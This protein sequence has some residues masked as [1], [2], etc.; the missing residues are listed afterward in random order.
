MIATQNAAGI[1]MNI[2]KNAQQP[3]NN[4]PQNAGRW[5]RCNTPVHLHN[6][7]TEMDNLMKNIGILSLSFILIAS[8]KQ[9]GSTNVAATIA[10][11][12][13]PAVTKDANNRIHIIYGSGDKL[14][15]TFSSDEGQTF[16]APELVGGLPGLIASATRGP[17]IAATK[18][19]IAVI[20]VNKDGDI[21]SYIKDQSGKWIETGKVNDVDTTDKESFIGLSSDNENNLFAIWTDLRGDHQNK[22]FGARSSDGGKT[23]M[24]NI[25]VYASPDGTICECCKPSIA[26]NGKNVFVMFRNW[27][28]GNRDLYLIQSCDGGESFGKAQKLGKG[29][30]ALD[31]CPMDGGGM[32]VDNSGNVQTVWRR[33]AKIYAC[34]PGKEEKEIG[35]GKNCGMENVNGK[36]IYTW[37]NNG[38]ITCLLSD[39][40]LKELGK[41]SSPVL[42][43]AGNDKLLCVWEDDAEIKTALIRL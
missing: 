4:A 22:I 43:A 21:F 40:S 3:A 30:W 9:Q 27:L 39:G 15:Y 37:T 20:A 25:L 13:M 6:L 33:E 24:K 14:M 2:V 42:K 17:Q 8:C 32:A 10:H 18:N 26:M 5:C 28:N 19:G 35:E 16:A 11:G 1:S 38:V 34:E 23:W 41:G 31:G 36:N 12:K 29:S 7:K